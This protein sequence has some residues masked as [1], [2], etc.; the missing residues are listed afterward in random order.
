MNKSI[1]TSRI[2]VVHDAK[3]FPC[4]WYNRIGGPITVEIDV[5]FEPTRVDPKLAC[6]GNICFEL[7]TF[8]S[9][10]LRL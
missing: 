7:H 9:G 6:S 8:S 4:G 5:A 2:Y 1:D 3:P 10:S